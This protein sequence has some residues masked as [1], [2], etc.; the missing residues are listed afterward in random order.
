MRIQGSVPVASPR[1]VFW[2]SLPCRFSG[3]LSRPAQTQEHVAREIMAGWL[4]DLPPAP[5][6]VKPDEEYW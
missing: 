1:P 6:A 5:A 4:R 2:P 3:T